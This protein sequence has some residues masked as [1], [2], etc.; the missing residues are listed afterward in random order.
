MS[1]KYALLHFAKHYY[2]LC[3]LTFPMHHIASHLHHYA[4]IQQ[5]A[6]TTIVEKHVRQYCLLR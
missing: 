1:F 6:H 3:V 4:S 5:P 2:L